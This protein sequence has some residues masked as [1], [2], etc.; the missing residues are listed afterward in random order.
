MTAFATG[1]S[2]ATS[3]TSKGPIERSVNC[4]MACTRPCR[5]RGFLLIDHVGDDVEEP[6]VGLARVEPEGG[7]DVEI[8][9]PE[10]IDQLGYVI[11]L[12][13]TSVA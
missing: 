9:P 2:G 6:L 4:F 10:L 5:L 12:R 8:V 3:F 11:D 7:L 1:S 13:S